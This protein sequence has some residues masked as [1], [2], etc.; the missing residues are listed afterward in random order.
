MVRWP[1]ARETSA[2]S[3][4]LRFAAKFAPVT[5]ISRRERLGSLTSGAEDSDTAEGIRPPCAGPGGGQDHRHR[6]PCQRAHCR[7][8]PA[9]DRDLQAHGDP[10]A[11]H[12]QGLTRAVRDADSQ[13]CGRHPRLQSARRRRSAASQSPRRR[14]HRD[15]VVKG[16]LAK[17]LGM[18]QLFNPDGTMTAVTVLE[19][20]PCKVLGLRTAE[21]DGYSAARIA[22]VPV[23]EDKLNSPRMGEF[24]KAGI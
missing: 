23:D 3:C 1:R 12:R 18:T 13:A 19:A 16:L 17:K 15:Q 9:P 10:V 6:P 8:D 20:G 14:E 4:H 22:F 21:K 2:T 24:K 7:P 5:A 11:V